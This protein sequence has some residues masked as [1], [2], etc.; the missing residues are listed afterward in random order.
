MSRFGYKG[1]PKTGTNG[2]GRDRAHVRQPGQCPVPVCRPD[3]PGPC[4]DLSPDE[5]HKAKLALD[6]RFA[7]WVAGIAA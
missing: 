7:G 6:P 2:P 3:S 5:K 4:P 1:V